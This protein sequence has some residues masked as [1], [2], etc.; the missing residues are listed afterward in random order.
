MPFVIKDILLE[1]IISQWDV[2]MYRLKTLETIILYTE[3]E[4]N[5]I[6]RTDSWSKHSISDQEKAI[7]LMADDT[8]FTLLDK[9]VTY[10][11]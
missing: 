1:F 4:N 9:L 6:L 7:N 10:L 2:M 11:G 3:K 8:V 5:N